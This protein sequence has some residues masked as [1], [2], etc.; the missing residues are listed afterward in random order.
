MG[1]WFGLYRL[2]PLVEQVAEFHRAIIPTAKKIEGFDPGKRTDLVTHRRS[3]VEKEFFDC[4]QH[5]W[6]HWRKNSK[7]ECLGNRRVDPVKDCVGASTFDPLRPTI[8]K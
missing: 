6:S 2:N 5:P 8:W 1:S 4:V 7:T 3:A